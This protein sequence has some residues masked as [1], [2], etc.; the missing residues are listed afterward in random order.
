MSGDGEKTNEKKVRKN[1][2]CNWGGKVNEKQQMK[3]RKEEH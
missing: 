1:R 2:T 3:L